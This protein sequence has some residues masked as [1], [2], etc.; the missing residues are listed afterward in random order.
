MTKPSRAKGGEDAGKPSRSVGDALRQAYD[1][2][3]GEAVPD[4]LLALLKK[5]D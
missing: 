2:T 5:L 1:E 4:D 3:V